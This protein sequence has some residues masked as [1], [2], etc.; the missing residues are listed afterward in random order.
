MTS[1]IMATGLRDND[2]QSG[3]ETTRQTDRQTDRQTERQTDR[4]ELA[5][6]NTAYLSF[7]IPPRSMGSSAG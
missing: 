1:C 3:R 5:K 2:G 6:I 4:N 7:N